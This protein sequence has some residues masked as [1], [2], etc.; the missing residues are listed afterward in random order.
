MFTDEI[1]IKQ[2]SRI[3][4]ALERISFAMEKPQEQHREMPPSPHPA[5]N[6]MNEKDAAKY[7][8]MSV[9]WFQRKRVTGGGPPFSKVGQSV[10]YSLRDLDYWLQYNTVAHTTEWS[11]RVSQKRTEF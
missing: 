2:L 6:M 1:I 3:A 7:L 11:E 4:D 9:A 8:G 10:R 5:S